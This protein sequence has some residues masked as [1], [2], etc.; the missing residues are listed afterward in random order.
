[1]GLFIIPDRVEET[2]STTGSLST[3][4]TISLGGA[5]SANLQSFS[6]AVGNSNSCY[7]TVESGNGTDWA[8]CRGTVT[9]G[10]PNTL[11][12]DE[13]FDTSSGGCTLSGTSTVFSST[14][15][16][17]LRS[18]GAQSLRM[19]TVSST[20]L[21][22]WL[23]Q[24]TSTF[25]D[26]DAGPTLY[27]PN[28]GTT[29]K[30]SGVYKASPATP[31]SVRA[32]VAMTFDP[33]NT[34]SRSPTICLGWYDG[35]TKTSSVCIQAIGAT[36]GNYWVLLAD[37]QYTTTGFV[38][39]TYSSNRAMIVASCWFRIRDDGTNVHYD[40]SN[41]EDGSNFF[42]LYSVA[43]ASGYLGATGYSNVFLSALS[44]NSDVYGVVKSWQLG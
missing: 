25:T 16:E 30:L 21:S 23:N 10:T 2:T 27:V 13:I 20:G 26:T 15:K 14:L 44:Y 6:A 1:M 36:N 32:K 31:Y 4:T 39:T 5:S 3:S 42:N 28:S 9:T 7:F 24:G 33:V 35:A 12:V 17:M 34:A 19:P 37:N 29:N 8:T 38:G 22:T 40:W 18:V 43:K 41:A 11:S